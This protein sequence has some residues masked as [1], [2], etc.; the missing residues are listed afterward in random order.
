MKKYLIIIWLLPLSVWSQL[1]FESNKLKLDFVKLPAIESLMS[2]SL[3]LKPNFTSDN[4]KK[5]PSFKLNKKNY[6]EPVSMFDA[7][8][9]NENY[10]KSDLQISLDPR[11]LGIYGGNSSYS[12]DGATKVKNISYKASQGYLRPELMPYSYGFYQRPHR[13]RGLHFGYRAYGPYTQ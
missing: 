8:V 9:A 2:T 10:V 4:N 5:L 6:R 11:E 1:D 7:M 3:D 12:P 13:R